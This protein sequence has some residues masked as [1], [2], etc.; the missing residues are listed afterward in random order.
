MTTSIPV[1]WLIVGFTAQ[2]M[3]FLRFLVQWICSE[4]LHRSVVPVAFWYFSLAGGAGL[5]AYAIARSDPVIIAGQAFGLIVY[6]RNL[7]LIY[8]NKR[9]A[10]SQRPS[11]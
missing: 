2:A 1:I 3:F 5:L 9:K 8:T 10:V 4:W 6:S 7:C 11:I